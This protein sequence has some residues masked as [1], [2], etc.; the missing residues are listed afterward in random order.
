MLSGGHVYVSFSR[1]DSAVEVESMWVRSVVDADR[2]NSDVEVE[3][4][5]VQSAVEAD[6]YQF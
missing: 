1:G 2:G 6:R 3:S 5:W 4:V